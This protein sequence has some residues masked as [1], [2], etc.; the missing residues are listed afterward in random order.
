MT[1]TENLPELPTGW[2]WASLKEL[3]TD[4]KN[5]IVDGPFG[6]NLKASEYV[7]E[8]I[9]IIR[10]QNIERFQFLDKNIRYVTPEKADE[11][12]RHIFSKNDIVI[13]KLGAPLGKACLVPENFDWGIIV[14]DV[15]RLRF[16]DKLFQKKF[17]MYAINSDISAKQLEVKTKG[18]TRPRVNL[19][20]IRDLLIP[21]PPL[22]EQ[23]RI[24][25]KIEEFFTDLDAGVQDLEKAKIQIKNY[26]QAILKAAFEGELTVNLRELNLVKA[27]SAST[28][29]EIILRE[30]K[31]LG[32]KL[33]DYKLEE[34]NLPRIPVTWIWVA[35]GNLFEVKP[36]G[37][38]L[39][40][41][42]EYWNGNIPWVSSG[43]V[44]NCIINE[45]QELITQLGVENSNAKTNAPGTVLLAMIG[46]GKTRGQVAIL[47]IEAATNQNVAAIRCANTPILPKYVFFW[48]QSRYEKNRTKGSGGMQQ[49]LNARIIK[50]IP[51]PIPPIEEQRVIVFEIERH[52]SVIDQIE[53]IIDQSLIQAEKLRQSILKKAFEGKLV[54]Q[55]TNNESASILLEKAK[56]EKG[57]LAASNSIKRKPTSKLKTTEMRKMK[58]SEADIQNADLYKILNSSNSRSLTPKKLWQ[59]SKL[60]IE[61]FYERLKVEVEKGRIVER[62]PNNI[63]VYLEIHE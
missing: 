51:I 56:K 35:I 50:E 46:E 45:T 18:T 42:P 21:L 37:T 48:L 24:V 3:A 63:D 15:V 61:D 7:D 6:S 22:H 29:V 34:S 59:L 31:K 25:Q 10:L 1:D 2:C 30:Q 60:D 43:E 32:K 47:N 36:G 54:P 23:H 13:T 58:S 26:R 11:L 49:A 5:D 41:E 12:K 27:E 40:K 52:F 33:E 57:N 44:A 16:D 20:H 17:V 55:S 39:R 62:R 38:P 14:A 28:L 4:P 8:G 19:N 9:P 53:K